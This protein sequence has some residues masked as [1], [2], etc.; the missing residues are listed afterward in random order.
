MY[1]HVKTAEG[2]GVKFGTG[3]DVSVITH[4]LLSIPRERR[5]GKKLVEN[6]K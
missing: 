1:M 4:R 2:F 3:I 5:R 6:K